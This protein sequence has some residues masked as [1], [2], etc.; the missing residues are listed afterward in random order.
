MLLRNASSKVFGK[1]LYP[2]IRNVPGRIRWISR[3]KASGDY[4]YRGFVSYSL[5][6]FSFPSLKGLEKEKT[7]RRRLA[8]K[9]L[10]GKY[11]K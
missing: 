6:L 5:A 9:H 7:G 8:G 4:V 2:V 3:Q 10:I 1:D 11:Q